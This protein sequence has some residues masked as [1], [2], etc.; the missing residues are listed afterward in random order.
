MK[1]SRIVEAL[2]AYF[3]LGG[4]RA[5]GA[6][7]EHK[8]RHNFPA[9]PMRV[10]GIAHPVWIRVQTSDLWSLQ[11]VLIRREYDCSL[12]ADPKVIIDAGANIGTASVFYANR[13]PEARIYA[14]EPDPSNFLMLQKNTCS[15]PA[16]TPVWG[17]L[18]KDDQ[19]VKI[20]P[21]Q[22][23][24]H[25]GVRVLDEGTQVPSF[26]VPS[27][28]NRYGLD[29]VDILKL[30]IEGAEY[31]VLCTAPEW[32][33]RVGIIA[34]ETHDRF[35]PGC[36]DMFESVASKFPFRQQKGDV[37]FACRTAKG[38]SRP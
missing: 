6:L 33:E 10:P 34:I 32:T 24:S 5:V 17:A 16:V 36:S 29:F 13:Y 14:I 21:P 7:I 12:A 23:F 30:D 25:W 15:Y 38:A 22:T 26:T 31:E 4:L 37:A 18:W 11:Q 19:S 3:P 1:V 9:V 2:K 27:M 8:L 35:R 20:A 28:M